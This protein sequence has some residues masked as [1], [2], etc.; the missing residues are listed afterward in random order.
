M[1]TL[2]EIQF[3]NEA[4]KMMTNLRLFKVYWSGHHYGFTRRDHKARL[5]Q[6]FELPSYELRYLYWDGYPLKFLPTHFDGDN[7]V[8]LILRSSNIKQIWKGNTV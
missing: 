3:T 2:K 5:P 8:E 6:N 4:F 7:L 1:A